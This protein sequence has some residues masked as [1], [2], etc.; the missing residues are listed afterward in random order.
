M[1]LHSRR[2]FAQAV[3]ILMIQ[4]K[5]NAAL[6]IIEGEVEIDFLG[7]LDLADIVAQLFGDVLRPEADRPLFRGQD[8]DPGID[9]GA[10]RDHG[11]V[12]DETAIDFWILL[13]RFRHCHVDTGL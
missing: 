8:T 1:F 11:G 4:G 3:E 6:F 9:P 13:D 2:S 12:L 7:I 5:A 10:G